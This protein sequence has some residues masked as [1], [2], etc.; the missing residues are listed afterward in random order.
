MQIKICQLQHIYKK[1]E[2]QNFNQG[3]NRDPAWIYKK[4]KFLQV[5]NQKENEDRAQAN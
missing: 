4:M 3:K 5:C 1:K 2:E